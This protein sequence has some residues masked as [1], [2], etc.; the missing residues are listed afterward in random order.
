VNITCQFSIYP[1]GVARLGPHLDAAL[2]ALRRRGLDPEL[3][4]MSSMVAGPLGQVMPALADA[5][6]AAA[7]DGCV[8]VLTVSNACPVP[9]ATP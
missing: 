3:G 5:F 7:S 1:L 4:P 8:M 2:D 6:A 9:G